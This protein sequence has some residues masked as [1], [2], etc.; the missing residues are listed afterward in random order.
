MGCNLIKWGGDVNGKKSEIFSN[1]L[2]SDWSVFHMR[3]A[4]NL[5]IRRHKRDV[6]DARGGDNDLIRGIT[7]KFP[8]KL[9]GFDR[10]LW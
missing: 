4:Q 5:S 8:G 9:G 6:K 3:I 10:D 7:V 2:R 1:Y